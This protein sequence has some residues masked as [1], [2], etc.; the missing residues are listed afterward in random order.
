MLGHVCP[1]QN[2]VESLLMCTAPLNSILL[3]FLEPRK[4]KEKQQQEA[5]K[6]GH[7]AALTSGDTVADASSFVTLAYFIPVFKVWPWNS[8]AIVTWQLFLN[9]KQSQTYGIRNPGTKLL[10]F[11]ADICNLL[12]EASHSPLPSSRFYIRTDSSKA[13][14]SQ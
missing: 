8:N 1:G 6:A 5:G 3:S 7:W 2:L 9:A 4:T 13:R 10:L 12:I 11:P 14:V